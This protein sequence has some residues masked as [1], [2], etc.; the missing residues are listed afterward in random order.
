MCFQGNNSSID[1][2][3]ELTDLLY[4]LKKVFRYNRGQF[5]KEKRVEHTCTTGHT[6]IDSIFYYGKLPSHPLWM[7]EITDG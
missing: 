3:I 2:G 5:P 4:K 1:D 6:P 7:V